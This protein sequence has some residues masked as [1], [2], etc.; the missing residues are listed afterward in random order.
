MEELYLY[1][2]MPFVALKSLGKNPKCITI[3]NDD[4]EKITTD[5]NNFD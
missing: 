5:L 1:S 2:E 3:T 4:I